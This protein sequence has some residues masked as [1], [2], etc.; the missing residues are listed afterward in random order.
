MIFPIA[1][2]NRYEALVRVAR[3]D[4]HHGRECLRI[5][6]VMEFGPAPAE[7]EQDGRSSSVGH[8][9]RLDVILMARRRMRSHVLARRYRH[10]EY[11][12]RAAQVR[13]GAGHPV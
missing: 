7:I 3:I 10:Y 9:L 12:L 1:G 11:N 5:A 2:G 4:A 8:I 13:P 6:Q